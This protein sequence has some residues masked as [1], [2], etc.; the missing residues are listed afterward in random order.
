MPYNR[1]SQT[2]YV[3]GGGSPEAIN[4]T[5]L[6]KPGELGS[7]IDYA[8]KS[9]QLIQVDS[10][11]TAATAAGVPLAGHVAMWK[12]RSSYI[13]T[14]D[15]AQAENIA[16]DVRN[17][18]A[19]VFNSLTSGAAGTASITP[20]SFGCIQQ[21][22]THVGILTNGTAA[23]AGDTLVA[24]ATAT[25]GTAAAVRVAAGTAPTCQV[26]GVATA[27]T[28]AVTTNYTPARLGWDTVDVP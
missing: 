20:G 19:G 14:N 15:K 9:Y 11:A 2:L 24:V 27:A 21:R 26:I 23:A 18:I 28:S 16:G 3:G 10:G 1:T 8:G 7:R 22:G 13:V 6:Y 25:S 17:S 4:V 12:S 5:T